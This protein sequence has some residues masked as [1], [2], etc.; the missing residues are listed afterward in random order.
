MNTFEIVSVWPKLV[1]C[2]FWNWQADNELI[3]GPLLVLTV[4]GAMAVNTVNARMGCI[5]AT[6]TAGSAVGTSWRP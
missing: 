2:S 6:P 1:G 5:V 3:T 4:A